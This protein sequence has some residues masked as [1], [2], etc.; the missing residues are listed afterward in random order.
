MRTWHIANTIVL[1]ATTFTI[2]TACSEKDTSAPPAPWVDPI[3][4]PTDQQD[5]VITGAA[6]YGAKVKITGGVAPVE[7]EAN[8]FTALFRAEVEINSAIPA[9][10]VSVASTLRFVAVDA[11]GNESPATLVDLIYGPQPGEPATFNFTLTGTA[12]SGSVPAGDAVTYDYEVLDAYDAPAT[13]PVLIVT[14]S[15]SAVI[16]DDGLSGSG[17]ILNLTRVGTYVITA[18]VAGSALQEQ[19]TFDVGYAVGQRFVDLITSVATMATGDTLESLVLVRDM[20]GNILADPTVTF[21]VDTS[22]CSAPA[23]CVTD[24][25]GGSFTIHEVGIFEVTASYT[26]DNGTFT[27]IAYVGVQPVIDV[28]PPEVS[29]ENVVVAGGACTSPCSATPGDQVNFDVVATDLGGL[30]Q[31]SYGAFFETAGSLRSRTVLVPGGSTTYTV[32]FTFSVPGGTGIEQ[33]PIVA[34]AIDAFGNIANSPG[35]VLDVLPISVQSADG[36]TRTITAVASPT[37]GVN[38]EAA[39]YDDTGRLIIADSNANR[40]LYTTSYANT[41]VL[42]S[43]AP[44]GDP[45]PEYLAS[46]S[47]GNIYA[48]VRGATDGIIQVDSA[49]S[50]VL[51]LDVNN[52][53]HTTNNLCDAGNG[54]GQAP[55]GVAVLPV[56]RGKVRLGATQPASGDLFTM[57]DPVPTTKTFTFGTGV[58]I[59]ADLCAT[60]N[61]LKTAYDGTA[62]AALTGLSGS[63]LAGSYADLEFVGTGTL[64]SGDV[65]MSTTAAGA[66]V[67]LS[68]PVAAEDTLFF[69][70]NT[71]YAF[72]MSAATPD[73]CYNLRH[74]LR[75]GLGNGFV[76]DAGIA[77]TF[78]GSPGHLTLYAADVG[79]NRVDRL[80]VASASLSQ[81]SNNVQNP[82]ALVAAPS[83]CVLV[84][85]GGNN[86]ISQLDTRT[87][88]SGCT[89]TTMVDGFNNIQ[90]LNLDYHEVMADRSDDASTVILLQ[91]RLAGIAGDLLALA[92]SSANLTVSGASFTGGAVGVRATGSISV[93][94]AASEGETLTVG[95]HV[96]ELDTSSNG[97]V[98][99]HVPVRPSG[100]AGASAADVAAALLSAIRQTEARL[101]AT[102]I[103]VNAVIEILPSL[104]TNDCF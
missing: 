10:E 21:A 41:A 74:D 39:L 18:Q 86:R 15:P 52:D 91:A 82:T 46:D 55:H 37:G 47:L 87:C 35:F 36:A 96:Y 8:D 5:L 57:L 17:S 22:G 9:G 3:A 59:G 27:D 102:D 25:G 83:G 20:Y 49:G 23:S 38:P 31:L 101:L 100:G 61:N 43:L 95:N 70:S 44:F 76:A 66:A 40:I 24:L 69:G 67:T 2:L 85:E 94:G 72:Q 65:T 104:E 75:G 93:G 103:G 4:S 71:Q 79:N 78:Q 11:A 34:Q 97:V 88:T 7:V 48:S 99:G 73:G 16:V 26:D 28:Y 32:A 81:V 6:E 29:I 63:C 53:V 14:T 64:I 60:R 98:A 56:V 80:D 62:F 42:A 54:D 12:A 84:A 30:S 19:R 77:A 45:N 90:G 51:L 13:A 58:A 33:V 89:R 50:A 68:Q 1:V 92:E